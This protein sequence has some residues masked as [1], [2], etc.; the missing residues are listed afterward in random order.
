MRGRLSPLIL[1]ER[2]PSV[3]PHKLKV[4]PFRALLLPGYEDVST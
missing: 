1:V 2:L 4:N 3:L